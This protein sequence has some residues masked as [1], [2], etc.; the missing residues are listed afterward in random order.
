M[1]CDCRQRLHVALAWLQKSDIWLTRRVGLAINARISDLHGVGSSRAKQSSISIVGSS[2][3]IKGHRFPQKSQ[4]AVASCWRNTSRRKERDTGWAL[5]VAPPPRQPRT[6][7]STSTSRS[8]SRH[9]IL[10]IWRLE[11]T[12]IRPPTSSDQLQ[13]TSSQCIMWASQLILTQSTCSIDPISASICCT[14]RCP[15]CCSRSQEDAALK[16][17]L[18][19]QVRLKHD[20]SALPRPLRAPKSDRGS[21]LTLAFPASRLRSRLRSRLQLR[22]PWAARHS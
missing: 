19:E 4:I 18:L 14:R 2:A 3:A 5:R 1:S 21:S 16:I 15:G 12:H 6:R 22:R 8:N 9:A 17:P 10:R 11:A 20:D 7:C 13:V